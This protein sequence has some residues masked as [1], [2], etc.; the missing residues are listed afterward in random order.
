MVPDERPGDGDPLLLP[1]GEPRP[2]LPHHRVVLL[3]KPPDEVS[4]VGRVDR[5]LDVEVGDAVAAHPDIVGDA[6]VE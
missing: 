4:G 1:A 3:R 2:A 5:D 6:A